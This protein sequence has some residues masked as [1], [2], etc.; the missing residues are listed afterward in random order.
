MFQCAFPYCQSTRCVALVTLPTFAHAL[1]AFPCDIGPATPAFARIYL[2]LSHLSYLASSKIQ[3]VLAMTPQEEA[4]IVDACQTHKT[5]NWKIRDYRAAI[6]I[7]ND[8]FVKY[9]DIR[10]LATEVAT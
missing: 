10:T 4:N 6:F 1:P 8:Y 2:F 7:C 9:G 5:N 3:V